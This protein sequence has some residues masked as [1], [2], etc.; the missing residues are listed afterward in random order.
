MTLSH[1]AELN[2]KADAKLKPG[3]DLKTRAFPLGH[4]TLIAFLVTK[5]LGLFEPLV[6]LS[7]KG[8]TQ[9]YFPCKLIRSLKEMINTKDLI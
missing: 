2:K 3:S 9:R 4:Q 7:E 6:S 1:T 5:L 8:G